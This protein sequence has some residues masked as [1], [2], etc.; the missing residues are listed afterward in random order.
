MT[1]TNI[2][3]IDFPLVGWSTETSTAL[4]TRWNCHH[5]VSFLSGERTHQR[6]RETE[7]GTKSKCMVL[8]VILL[9]LVL[10]LQ[11]AKSNETRSLLQA[12][13]MKWPNDMRFSFCIVAMN[14]HN[15]LR[16]N[17]FNAIPINSIVVTLSLLPLVHSPHPNPSSH[18]HT[19]PL[20]SFGYSLVRLCCRAV[21]N[22]CFL[23]CLHSGM[24]NNKSP[25]TDTYI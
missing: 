2:N 14:L 4:Q 12:F 11:V 9:S 20:A 10:I 21:S 5:N 22:Q 1:K 24:T 16:N 7:N 17:W 13:N 3:S 18:L 25:C 8:R 23:G 19:R 15:L 6:E